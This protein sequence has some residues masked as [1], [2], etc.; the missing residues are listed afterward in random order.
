MNLTLRPLA[1][2]DAPVF[3]RLRLHALRSDPGMYFSSYDEVAKRTDDEWRELARGDD[4]H[5]V[6]G[7]FDGAVLVGISAVFADRT[8]EPGSTAIFAMSYILPSYRGRGLARR[9][10][11]ARVTWV[12][13]RPQF[14]RIVVSH[15][16]SNAPSR[17]AMLRAGFTEV[18][19]AARTWPDG[20]LED[21]L[22]YELPIP[23]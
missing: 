9:F 19:A 1:E 2:S 12:R 8:T 21:E 11:E 16:R 3:R 6:F 13:E 7:L 18:G 22:L 15:R 10:Y 17:R 20:E 4:L 5:C 14:E 23:R